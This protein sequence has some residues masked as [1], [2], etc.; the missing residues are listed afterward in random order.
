LNVPIIKG[1]D[2]TAA[3][4]YDHYDDFGE[5]TTGKAGF[6]W[7]PTRGFLLRGSVGT[8]FH[9]PSVPQ[10]KAAPQSYGVTEDPYTCTP[11]LQAV[12]TSLGAQCQP[13][14][15]QYDVVAGGNELLK[16]EKSEQATLGFR[17]EPTQEL[18]FGADLWWVGI[19][20]SFGQLAEAT[21]FANP[22][23]YPGAWTTA[24]D[25][26]TGVTYL[27]FNAG[28]LNLGKSYTSGVDIDAVGRFKFD[29][30]SLTSQLNATYML[31]ERFQQEP[32]GAYFTAI[33]D[34]STGSLTYRLRGSWRN[35][36]K[37]GPFAH[38]LAFNFRSGY[39]DSVTA[40]EE[41]DASGNVVDDDATVQLKV[42]PYY[43][44]DWQTGWDIS[45]MFNVTVGI[46]NIG[47]EK[48]PLVLTTTGG[49]QV[50]YDGNLYD[51]RG[52]TYYINGTIKF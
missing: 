45:K 9:A 6:R 10:V 24:T 38:T 48:P 50:G 29:F 36:L 3:I 18:S 15:R 34:N 42:K 47:D 35:T 28:N 30:G 49:Q 2:V 11:E 37:H 39:K 4:R 8:G 25:I 27:A 22:Q 51:P 26:G 32:N 5:A 7:T 17:I 19:K 16:P 13:A 14:G 21:V 20:D 52:R 23:S 44:F 33:G 43:T 1:L 31:R 12:A 40:V 46:L 41:L